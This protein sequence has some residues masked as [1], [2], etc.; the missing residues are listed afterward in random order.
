MQMYSKNDDGASASPRSTGKRVYGVHRT[1]QTADDRVGRRPVAEGVHVVVGAG[2]I[3]VGIAEA[4][5]AS[6]NR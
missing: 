2:P 6:G 3:G 4:L 1:D 5:T